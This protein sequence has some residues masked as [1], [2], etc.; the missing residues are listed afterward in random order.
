MSKKVLIKNKASGELEMATLVENVDQAE[1]VKAEA[2]WKPVREAAVSLLRGQG[3][4]DLQIAGRL[5][6]A[7]WDWVAKVPAAWLPGF[8]WFKLVGIKHDDLW[9]GLLLLE[10]AKR[11]ACLSPDRGKPLVYVDYLESAPWNLADFVERPKYGLIGF[12][13]MEYAIRYSQSEGFHGRVGLLALPQA[14]AFYERGCGMVRVTHAGQHGMAWFEF[15][16]ELAA[17]FLSG[18]AK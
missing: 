16:R 12:R 4:T 13:L 14:E 8:E 6:H 18:G 3:L 9:Q 1:L 11:A 5:Q 7:H 2:S 17:L 10:T 15:T